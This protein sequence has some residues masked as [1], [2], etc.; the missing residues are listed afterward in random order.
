MEHSR[1]A[2]NALNVGLGLKMWVQKKPGWVL[3][4]RNLVVQ[5]PSTNLYS[6]VHT[7]PRDSVMW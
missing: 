4:L 1:K 7:G 5:N 6:P 2:S 3:E